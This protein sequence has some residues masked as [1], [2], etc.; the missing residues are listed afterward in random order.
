MVFDAKARKWI[1]THLLADKY[2][3][4]NNMYAA[5]MGAHKHHKDFNK[6]N[7][8]PDNIIRMTAEAH[9]QLHRE[10]IK[11]TLHRSEAIEKCNKIKRSPEYRQRFPGL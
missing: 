6:L 1:F 9:L 11:L 4:E 5:K 3:L 2:N 8:N 7:N 10:H